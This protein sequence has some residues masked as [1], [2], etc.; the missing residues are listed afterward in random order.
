MD[1]VIQPE[2]VERLD[3]MDNVGVDHTVDVVEVPVGE[4]A[5]LV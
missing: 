3:T 5:L 4:A 1:I 2:E